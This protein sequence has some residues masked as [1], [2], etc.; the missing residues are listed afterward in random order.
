VV[1]ENGEAEIK[2]QLPD[3]LTG[4]RVLALALTPSDRMGLGEAS[5]KVNLD[6]EIRP[7]MP[8]QLTGGDYFLAGFNIM[9]RTD[10]A[11]DISVN[12]K[13]TGNVVGEGEEQFSQTI[14]LK[15]YKRQTVY[16]PITASKS[17]GDIN[18]IA[19]AIDAIGSD[20]IK[21]S[22]PVNKRRSLEVA[23]NYGATVADAKVVESISLPANIHADVGDIS[24]SLAPSVI[25]N[26]EGAFR[27]MR[28]YPYSCWEQQLSKAVMAS[29]Y[30]SLQDYLSHQLK[31]PESEALVAK[32]L[33]IAANYQAAN[34]GMAY[35]K[36]E[37]HYVS[38]YLSAYTALAFNWLADKG[39]QAQVPQAVQ[40]KLHAY[41]ER[42]LRQDLADVPDFYS[43]G[44]FATLRAVSLAA[45][46]WHGKVSLD[47][48]ERYRP[49]V[50]YM[51]LFGKAHYL[52]AASQVKGAENIIAEVSTMILA[53]SYQSAAKVSFNEVVDGDHA[54]ILATP[55][56]SNCSILSAFTKIDQSLVDGIPPKLVRFI[57]Q[58]RDRRDHFS[59][60]QENSFCLNSLVDYAQ[61][62]E[63]IQPKMDISVRIDDQQLGQASFNSVTDDAITLTKPIAQA[64]IGKK[65]SLTISSQGDGQLYYLTRV[66]YAPLD[67]HSARINA[68]IDIRKEYSVERDS[69]WVL[70]DQPISKVKRGELIRVD[71]YVSLP[72][73]RNFVV[74]DDPLPGGLELINRDLATA[75]TIDANKA[76]TKAAS[77]SWWF[78][79]DDWRYGLSRWGFYHQELRHDAARFYADYLPAGN[80]HLSYTAQ[81]IATGKFSKMPVHA[82]EM[83]EPD[84]FGKGISTTLSID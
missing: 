3:N 16:M 45:L 24:V 37:N 66:A 44:I 78:K 58:S 13:A 26:I 21:H 51:S 77:G 15:P 32:T 8:N 7:V 42:L 38:P 27:Y 70:L 19:T 55:L 53:S 18:F 49:H 29:H 76:D 6:T 34:G 69:K 25:G 46:S 73:A 83:Y 74:V 52:Q 40:T 43:R 75:S 84:V 71:I 72:T 59:N 41:L 61:S 33:A 79:F 10:Q 9:N 82:E 39:Y 54:R 67:G 28:D 65:H 12:I 35:F 62:Y 80:Y 63:N 23:A 60:T 5:F 57:T 17:G 48:L 30:Q 22:L 56:R 81:A 11:R 64:D 4:W 14:S 31:W 50:Q 68:G 36:P 1:N 20:S 47:D 2:F